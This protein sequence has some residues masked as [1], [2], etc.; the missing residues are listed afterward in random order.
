[1]VCRTQF[2][3]YRGELKTLECRKTEKGRTYLKK[4]HRLPGY[5]SSSAQML[6]PSPPKA[7]LGLV[8]RLW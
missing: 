6:L 4:R 5:I 2:M 8:V 1:M 3:I 7:D